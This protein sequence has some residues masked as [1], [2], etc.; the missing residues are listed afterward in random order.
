MCIRDR[1]LSA[2]GYDPDG[3]K[4]TFS[5]ELGPCAAPVSE[6]ALTATNADVRIIPGCD[7]ATIVLTWTDSKGASAS[8]E[9]NLTR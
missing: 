8:T 6:G 7:A 2:Q 9:W 1:G 4:T 5:W 3:D